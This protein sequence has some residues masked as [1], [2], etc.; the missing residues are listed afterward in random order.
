M[1]IKVKRVLEMLQD[2]NPEAEFE[3]VMDGQ[4]PAKNIFVSCGYRNHVEKNKNSIKME[5]K[6]C[7][8]VTF[9]IVI[10]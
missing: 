3:I 4:I 8:V 9:N 6:N 5:P 10:E 2:C 1:K 7:D